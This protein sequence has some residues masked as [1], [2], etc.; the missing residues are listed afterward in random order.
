M[1]GQ[2]N[3]YENLS[4]C[5]AVSINSMEPK[6]HSRSFPVIFA[7]KVMMLVVFLTGL[8]TRLGLIPSFKLSNCITIMTSYWAMMQ[9]FPL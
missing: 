4:G 6:F 8:N 1:Q 5:Y 9:K 3:R 2:C 7:N